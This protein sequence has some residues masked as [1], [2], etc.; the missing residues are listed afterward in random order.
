MQCLQDAHEL[1][2]QII[3]QLS[4]ELSAEA[5]LSAI[6]SPSVNNFQFS[7]QQNICCD[8]LDALISPLIP[9]QWGSDV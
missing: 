8:R 1:L 9:R 5:S 3:D 7:L 6:D 4:E 2:C